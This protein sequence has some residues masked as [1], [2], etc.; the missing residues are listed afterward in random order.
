[1]FPGDE[2]AVNPTSNVANNPFLLNEEIWIR[3]RWQTVWFVGSREPS[4]WRIFS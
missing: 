1:M 4:R 2:L 3:G